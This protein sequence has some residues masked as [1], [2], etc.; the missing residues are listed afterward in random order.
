MKLKVLGSSSNGNCYLL[1]N[2]NSCLVIE[3]GVKFKEVKKALDYNINKIC[4]CIIT[5]EHKDHSGY[6][7]E[8]LKCGINCY[9]SEGT[10]EML[11]CESFYIKKIKALQV[12]CVGEFKIMPFNTKHDCKEPLGYLIN[13]KECGNV[14]FATDTYYLPNT[15]RNLNNILIECNYSMDILRDNNI[16][17]S[18]KKRI[19]S[20]HLS[21]DTCIGVL[22]A[23][24]LSNVENIV[25]IHLSDNN[26]NA[27][28]FK[29]R[30]ECATGIP[31]VVAENGI[32][33]DL[34]L[35]LR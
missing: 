30:V 27:P 33:V 18:L 35:K 16:N 25:L 21:I 24:D 3:A 19:I 22:N 7:N 5:H 28:E 32:E 8:Y 34:K 31:T 2:K 29:T 11:G 9:M 12:F 6:I 4:S 10:A 15:F 1:E 26:S 23:N 20:S 14:L 13:H 17:E